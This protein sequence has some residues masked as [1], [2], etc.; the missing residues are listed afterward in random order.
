MI[1]DMVVQRPEPGPWFVYKCIQNCVM[2]ADLASADIMLRCHVLQ[3]TNTME[4]KLASRHA[5]L[6][7]LDHF[8]GVPDLH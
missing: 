7:Y 1:G 3:E 2:D 8:Q 6:G 5:A 4:E